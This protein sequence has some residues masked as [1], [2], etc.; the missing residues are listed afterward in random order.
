MVSISKY[1]TFT[2]LLAISS[3]STSSELENVCFDNKKH[4]NK[5]HINEHI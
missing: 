3:H 1:D 2:K 5:G 4:L